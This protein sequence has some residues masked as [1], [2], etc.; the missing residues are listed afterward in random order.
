MA[1][2]RPPVL[3]VLLDNER[4]A[5]FQQIAQ[6]EGRSMGW[7]I[8][9]M[10]DRVIAANTIHVYGVSHPQSIAT[11]GQPM[12]VS[13]DYVSMAVLTEY[14]GDA[15]AP[16]SNDLL[17]LQAQVAEVKSD[18]DLTTE[19]IQRLIADAISKAPIATTAKAPAAVRT[20]PAQGGVHNEVLK[21][22]K[23]LDKE[24]ALK[25]AVIAGLAAGH[26]GEN[27][28]QYLAD[29]GFLNGNGGKYTGASNSRFRLA[30]EYL[31]NGGQTND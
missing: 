19:G 14:V 7:V 15:I 24:P 8:K 21:V 28:G 25:S 12:K 9:D 22:A 27:L 17:N 20:A 3:S 26:T 30:I 6:S 11:G 18:C 13:T 29:N 2:E 23:R 4:K 16:L 10:I 1:K 31:N 5:R